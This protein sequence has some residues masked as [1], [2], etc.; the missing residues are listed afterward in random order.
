MLAFKMLMKNEDSGRMVHE[1]QKN[2]SKSLEVVTLGVA[3]SGA[4]YSFIA[5]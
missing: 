3:V 2:T 4:W 5:G 1:Q